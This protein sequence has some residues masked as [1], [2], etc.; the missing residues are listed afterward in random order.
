MR[1][2]TRHALLALAL[3]AVLAPGCRSVDS[4]KSPLRIGVVEDS[5]PLVFRHQGRWSGVE[6][7]LGRA[8][9]ARLG[10]KPVF[11]AC[12]PARLSAA[13]LE[14]KV[15]VLMAGLTI[16]EERRVQMD[17]SSPYLVVGQAALVRSADLLRYNTAIKIR[18]ARVRVGVQEGSAGDRLVSRYFTGAVRTGF[19]RTDEAVATL[20]EDRIDM[21]VADAPAAW[22]LALQHPDRLAVAPALLAREE[23]AWGFRRGSVVLRESANRALADWQKDG[24]LEAILQRWIPYSK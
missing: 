15:D 8:L 1:I 18:T 7:E 5:P 23:I 12:P 3:A 22:W 21:L 16:T 13:L 14:G 9:A 24:T 4:A 2:P 10:L 19:A 11:V 6:V 17:F 20:L